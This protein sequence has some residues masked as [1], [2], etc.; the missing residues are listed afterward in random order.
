MWE[1]FSKKKKKRCFFYLLLDKNTAPGKCERD[2]KNIKELLECQ[3]AGK[4]C[5][6]F[7]DLVEDKNTAWNKI[8]EYSYHNFIYY[9]LPVLQMLEM[10][11]TC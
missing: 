10:K 4:V 6:A 8:M 1:S 9:D 3:E 5:S 11:R 7:F 2:R